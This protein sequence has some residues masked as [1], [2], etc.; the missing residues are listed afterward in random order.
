M[1]ALLRTL[2]A[3]ALILIG[4]FFALAIIVSFSDIVASIIGLFDHNSVESTAE[5]IGGIV[6]T[7][8]F[9]IIIYFSFRTAIRIFRNSKKMKD[10]PED[11][12]EILDDIK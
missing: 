2:L 7:V 1:T 6:A 10:E 3:I 5:H 12:I 8:L 9:L 11:S 4:S